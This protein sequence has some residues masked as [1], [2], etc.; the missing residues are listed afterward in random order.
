MTTSFS[1]TFRFLFSHSVKHSMWDGTRRLKLSTIG[2]AN[3]SEK[4]SCY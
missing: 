3:K 4:S 2:K 1:E